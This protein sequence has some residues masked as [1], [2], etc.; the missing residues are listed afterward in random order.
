[1]TLKDIMANTQEDQY[2][3]TRWN[4]LYNLSKEKAEDGL[5]FLMLTN[6][7]GCIA[8]LSF[9]G[10]QKDFLNTMMPY[11]LLTFTLGVISL[12]V[13][14]LIT[15]I[16]MNALFNSWMAS[17]HQYYSKSATY[18]E[19]YDKDVIDSKDKLHHLIF[20][21]MSFVLFILGCVLGGCAIF[22]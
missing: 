13:H 10:T 15:Y 22:S 6:G 14:H 19:I 20:A 2:I 11:S 1:M 3:A 5:R 17:S 18:N 21:Y 7:G 12:G 9:I 16:K 4:Q 8:T